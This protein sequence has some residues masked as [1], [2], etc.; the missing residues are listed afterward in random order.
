MD[1]PIEEWLERFNAG[2]YYA[3]HEAAELAWH[4]SAGRERDFLKGLVHAAVSL[5]H[6]HAL[7]PH[8]ARVKRDSALRYLAPYEPD[9]GGIA[10]S[11]L[12][13]ELRRFYDQSQPGR[14]SADVPPPLA[15]R[16]DQEPLPL[17]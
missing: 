6:H 14:P 7:N 17:N 3:A 12:R 1:A 16:Q 15:R 10:V 4:A 9:Y 2:E 13:R 5:H 8:G 11:T